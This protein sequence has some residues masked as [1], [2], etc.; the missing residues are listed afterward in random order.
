MGG[1]TY[2]YAYTYVCVYVCFQCSAHL[3]FT[4][5]LVLP[6]YL[7]YIYIDT[8]ISLSSFTKLSNLMFRQ[9]LHNVTTVCRIE[10]GF[11][12]KLC[13]ILVMLSLYFFNV[14]S[15]D[16]TLLSLQYIVTVSRSA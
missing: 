2:V 11:Q 12:Q 16:G 3:Y 1:Y 15:N 13:L 14:F 8:N 10:T 9:S 4:T 7:T 6:S 5:L